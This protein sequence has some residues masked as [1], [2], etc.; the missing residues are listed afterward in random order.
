[1]PKVLDKYITIDENILGGTPVISGTRIPVERIKVLLQQ[2]YSLE[3]LK[4]E[5]PQ[6][7]I[8]KVQFLMAYLLQVGLDAFTTYQKQKQ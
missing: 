6:I 1:M 7:D 8:K 5:Y 2:G 3:S 4:D